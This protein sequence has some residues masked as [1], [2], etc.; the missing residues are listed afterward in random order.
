MSYRQG[1]D[2]I[3]SG[4]T[5]S[6]KESPGTF[7]IIKNQTGLQALLRAF[8]VAW[9]GEM[10]GLMGQV[11]ELCSW[12][13]PFF[14]PSLLRQGGVGFHSWWFWANKPQNVTG[15]WKGQC[16]AFGRCSH[17]KWFIPELGS[18]STQSVLVVK[19]LILCIMGKESWKFRDYQ[20]AIYPSKQHQP[21]RS[22]CAPVAY[23]KRKKK[24]IKGS[25]QKVLHHQKT[26]RCFWWKD[27]FRQSIGHRT[28]RNMLGPCIAL[29][30]CCGPWIVLLMCNVRAI[31]QVLLVHRPGSLFS[32]SI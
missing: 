31:G 30:Q 27:Y 23:C 24:H 4:P 14:I 17:P 29:L 7:V 20:M 21:V 3:M 1:Q 9:E 19:T 28:G 32:F 25:R 11:P 15:L 6:W 2:P 22:L 13:L 5:F 8:S 12:G 26:F 18:Y 10:G 16:K